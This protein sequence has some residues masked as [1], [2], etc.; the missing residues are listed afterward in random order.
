MLLQRKHQELR[1]FIVC[2]LAV[3]SLD[4]HYILAKANDLHTLQTTLMQ[5]TLSFITDKGLILK[6]F[7]EIQEETG[8]SEISSLLNQT[9]LRFLQIESEINLWMQQ[10]AE[11]NL[12][13]VERKSTKFKIKWESLKIYDSRAQLKAIAKKMEIIAS[14]ASK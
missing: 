4:I 9:R 3:N 12:V 10:K 14:G 1:Q 11:P 5:K 2:K 13:E 6:H 7:Q 8:E